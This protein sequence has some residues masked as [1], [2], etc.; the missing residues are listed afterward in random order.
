MVVFYLNTLLTVYREINFTS[1]LVH[2]WKISRIK[3]NE[4]RRFRSPALDF[5]KSKDLDF[6]PPSTIP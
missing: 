3:R 2:F 4:K 6:C 1:V 5:K